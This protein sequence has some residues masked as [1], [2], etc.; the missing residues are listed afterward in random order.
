MGAERFEGNDFTLVAGATSIESELASVGTDV[1]QQ[2]D[3]VAPNQAA[4]STEAG[5]MGQKM[6]PAQ[7]VAGI[8]AQ[9]TVSRKEFGKH[10]VVVT[11]HNL[12]AKMADDVSD[13]VL[14]G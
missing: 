12:E 3:L 8:K 13:E 1:D 4:Q 10:G 2:V 6:V 14:Y 11:M 5:Y 9:L 7:E